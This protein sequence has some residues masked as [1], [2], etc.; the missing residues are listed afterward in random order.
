MLDLSPQKQFAD[1]QTISENISDYL[2]R[3]LFT[4]TFGAYS[5]YQLNDVLVECYA[6]ILQ[7]LT[8]YGISFNCDDSDLLSDFWVAHKLYSL[9]YFLDT[10]NLHN[11]LI[12]NSGDLEELTTLC[13]DDEEETIAEPM[14]SYL[15]QQH[16]SDV[17]L[18][19]IEYLL[20][21]LTSSSRLRDHVKAI[22]DNI[23]EV[24]AN[25]LIPDVER[26]KR[27]IAKTQLLRE[28]AT[29]AATKILDETDFVPAEDKPIV[30]KLLA[31]YDLDK[32][33]PDQIKIYSTIDLDQVSDFLKPLQKEMLDIHHK[34]VPHHIEYWL[35]PN[36][37]RPT[38]AHLVVLVAHHDE[39]DTD[40][41]SFWRDIEEMIRLGRSIFTEGQVSIIRAMANCLYPKGN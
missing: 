9:R 24:G 25:I 2:E 19:D 32:L 36:R 30:T 33:A 16:P 6:I 27:Y 3:E 39:P 20:I 41:S 4:E 23:N 28:L 13:D 21:D 17:Y 12:T 11:F 40:P 22:I 7:E 38:T 15:C 35:E 18:Q 31:D 10:N 29:K 26:T 1:L 37:P 14:F 5:D 34:R 8:E